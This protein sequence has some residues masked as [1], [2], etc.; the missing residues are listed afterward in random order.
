V[1]VVD[2][3]GLLSAAI[4]GS[5]CGKR[6][7]AQGSGGYPLGSDKC[8]VFS[9][10]RIICHDGLTRKHD[11]NNTRI[12]LRRQYYPGKNTFPRKRRGAPN[13]HATGARDER[14]RLAHAFAQLG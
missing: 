5:L 12:K 2:Q 7:L 11:L 6:D 1:V 14:T 13:W 3:Y 10:L 8:R 9:Y 4:D